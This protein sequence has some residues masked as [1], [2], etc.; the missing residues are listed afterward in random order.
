MRFSRL[1]IRGLMLAVAIVSVPLGVGLRAWRG[2]QLEEA[3][4]ERAFEDPMDLLKDFGDFTNVPLDG[5]P[6]LRGLVEPIVLMQGPHEGGSDNVWE[7]IVFMDGKQVERR[8]EYI[9]F[10][11]AGGE[12]RDTLMLGRKMLTARGPEE[13]AFLGLL[14]R[15]YRQDAEAR[16]FN[17][18]LKRSEFPGLSEPQKGKVMAVAILRALLKRN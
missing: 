1:S 13:R 7:G 15:W 3:R 12:I 17:D 8:A 18:H 4:R 11:Y 14:Q 9:I 6:Y 5:S 10:L 2:R 16:E